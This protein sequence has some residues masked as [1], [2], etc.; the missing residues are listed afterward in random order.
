MCVRERECIYKSLIIISYQ[1]LVVAT[2]VIFPFK[3]NMV[4]K[5]E[6]QEIVYGFP[7]PLNYITPNLKFYPLIFPSKGIY[8]NLRN[9]ANIMNIKKLKRVDHI[10]FIETLLQFLK[11]K[12]IIL[13][14]FLIDLDR[15]DYKLKL[16]YDTCQ[17][18]IINNIYQKYIIFNLEQF[19]I[20]KIRF[21]KIDRKNVYSKKNND[22]FIMQHS[23]R[24]YN[25]TICLQNS[26]LFSHINSILNNNLKKNYHTTTSKESI[27]R[28]N[29]L[30]DLISK[31][32]IT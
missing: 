21:P 32:L 5:S 12:Y 25:G 7:I 9:N 17:V 1:H 3:K 11:R 28:K 27:S 19:N 16:N 20:H 13:G 18:E 23:K 8:I 31:S 6:N 29:A 24:I 4:V 30:D 2:L 14:N 15:K 22:D 26:N 10:Y